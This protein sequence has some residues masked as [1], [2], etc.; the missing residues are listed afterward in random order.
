[1]PSIPAYG[2]FKRPAIAWAVASTAYTANFLDIFQSSMVLFGFSPIAEDL[3]FTPYD[4]NWVIVAYTITFATFL[5][6][7]GQFAD[8]WGVRTVFLVGAGTLFSQIF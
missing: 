7:V 1:M 2:N 5:L 6:S 4:I 8:R 3:H